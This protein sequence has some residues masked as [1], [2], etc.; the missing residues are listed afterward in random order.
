MNGLLK[1]EGPSSDFNSP[2][3]KSGCCTVVFGLLRCFFMTV[4][5][6]TIS[7][8]LCLGTGEEQSAQSSADILQ[9]DG[10]RAAG[11]S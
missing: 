1:W 8:S 5:K 9:A 7:C 3:E 6:H 10:S 11:G 2:E 4:F